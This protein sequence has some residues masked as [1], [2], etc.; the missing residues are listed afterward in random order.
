[1]KKINKYI[2]HIMNNAAEGTTADIACRFFKSNGV[3]IRSWTDTADANYANL[4]Y[5]VWF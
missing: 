3:K 4:K 2:R 1:M 5:D